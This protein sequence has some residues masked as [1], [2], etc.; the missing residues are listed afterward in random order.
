[1]KRIIF[2]IALALFAVQVSAATCNAMATEKK[3]AGAAKSSF[4]QKCEKDARAKCEASADK[5]T[6][7]GAARNSYIIKCTQ[8][9]AGVGSKAACEASADARNLSGAAR[10]SHIGK[11]MKDSEPSCCPTLRK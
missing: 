5:K 9:S 10:N 7:S 1:M 4:V 8:D 2:G 11:C 6:L 3:L